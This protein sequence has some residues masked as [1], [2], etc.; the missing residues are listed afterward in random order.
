MEERS[1][2]LA[3]FKWP[4][5]RTVGLLIFLIFIFI[6]GWGTFVIVPAGHRGVAL[7]WGSAEN[8]IMGE[9][10]KIQS[11]QDSLPAYLT[12]STK[13]SRDPHQFPL[14]GAWKKG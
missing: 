6:V 8:R 9:G 2:D 3:E 14:L 10:P 1:I 11:H 5:P 13:G 12:P 4:K 7:W